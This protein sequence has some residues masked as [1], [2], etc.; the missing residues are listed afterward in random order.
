[1]DLV[2]SVFLSET[3][4][5]GL[6]RNLCEP[7]QLMHS[8]LGLCRIKLWSVDCD[9]PHN[10]EKLR[11]MPLEV[12]ELSDQP[13]AVLPAPVPIS[14]SPP[15]PS[16]APP[17]KRISF[18]EEPPE[19]PEPPRANPKNSYRKSDDA[20]AQ[21]SALNKR[22]DRVPDELSKTSVLNSRYAQGHTAAD[23]SKAPE[24]G[25]HREHREPQ[26]PAKQKPVS[27][28]VADDPPVVK[29]K[30][31]AAS[32]QQQQQQQQAPQ[33]PAGGEEDMSAWLDSVFR[34]ALSGGAGGAGGAGQGLGN[35]QA[36]SRH[37][38]GGGDDLQTQVSS[39]SS[40]RRCHCNVHHT[41][42]RKR[43]LQISTAST[44]AK[45]RKP[46]SSKTFNQN[47][48]DRQVL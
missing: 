16:P 26:H 9:R 11:L 3:F 8:I 32:Q 5:M 23:T 47:E 2:S 37:M 17:P 27:P 21:G 45:S 33:K 28:P 38:K 36:V 13:V 10:A 44:K 29:R 42:Y 30:T 24:K 4:G 35:P 22:K 40:S 41:L 25:R 6:L 31:R 48:I 1:M 34:E 12:D 43:Y 19:Q 39:T 15:P 20:M 14:R 46:A 18:V 7:V